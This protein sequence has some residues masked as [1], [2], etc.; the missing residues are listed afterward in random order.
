MAVFW[1]LMF[2][3]TLG[4]LIVGLIRPSVLSRLFR[5]SFT[6]KKAGIIFGGLFVIVLILG[7]IFPAEKKEDSDQPAGTATKSP[8]QS[9][10]SAPTSTQTQ[11]VAAG[12][13]SQ[14]VQACQLLTKAEVESVMAEAIKAPQEVTGEYLPAKTCTYESVARDPIGEPKFKITLQYYTEGTYTNRPA[15]KQKPTASKIG[16]NSYFSESGI[17][18]LN[19]GNTLI[20]M[21]GN[22]TYQQE[23]DLGKLAFP[24]MP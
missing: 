20:N 19:K 22:I 7:T 1:S 18:F 8:P 16:D 4:L 24:R 23:E 11:V 2:L 9:Q 3:L 13:S 10:T 15:D 6:R 17:L 12:D 14:D 5:L 21:V